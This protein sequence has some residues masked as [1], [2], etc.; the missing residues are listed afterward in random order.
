METNGSDYF[1]S[2]QYF[3]LC[4]V[5]GRRGA[6]LGMFG[7]MECVHCEHL[8]DDARDARET[9]SDVEDMEV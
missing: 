2:A 3:E 1:N 8:R 5:C 7:R 6:W 4:K 9:F